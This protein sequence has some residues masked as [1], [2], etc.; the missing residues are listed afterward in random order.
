MSDSPAYVSPFLGAG[1]DWL[2]LLGVDG[3]LSLATTHHCRVTVGETPRPGLELRDAATTPTMHRQEARPMSTT[4]RSENDS[5]GAEEWREIPGWPGY[6]ASTHGRVRSTRRRGAGAPIILACSVDRDGYA[7]VNLCGASGARRQAARSVLVAETFIGPRPAPKM[8]V[9]HGNNVR[10][11]D[12]LI[13]LRWDTQVG[14]FADQL[15]HGT[16]QMGERSAVARL[17]EEQV[18]AI[19]ADT[20][21]DTVVAATFGVCKG[22]VHAIR[23]RRTWRHVA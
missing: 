7:K 19:R 23:T 10:L 5:Q 18:R 20:R 6:E 1:A 4:Q 14:N 15:R 8:H 17:T 21:G 2:A 22:N 13:N 16:R 3:A 12:R 11:D 9:C